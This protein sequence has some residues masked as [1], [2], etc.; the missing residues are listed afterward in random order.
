M[1]TIKIKNGEPMDR[2]I[3]GSIGLMDGW[4]D[5]LMGGWIYRSMN[6]LMDILMDIS[7]NG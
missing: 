3:D 6:W 1:L 7:I 2:W 5:G 4:F